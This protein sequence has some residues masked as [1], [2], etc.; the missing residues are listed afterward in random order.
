M[1]I[2]YNYKQSDV[3]MKDILLIPPMTQF[4]CI[5]GLIYKQ[6]SDFLLDYQ[7]AKF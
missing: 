4:K 3:K 5:G 2:N 6:A 1:K 7:H